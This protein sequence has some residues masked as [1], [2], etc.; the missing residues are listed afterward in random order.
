M[1]GA[2]VAYD[3]HQAR[4]FQALRRTTQRL[5]VSRRTARDAAEAKSRFLARA[6]H[7]LLTPLNGILGVTQVMQI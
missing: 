3:S 1:A 2:A 6:G 4:S 7:E 5:Q